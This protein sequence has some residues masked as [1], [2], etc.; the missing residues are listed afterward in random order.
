MN[1]SNESDEHVSRA[2]RI[3]P[4]AKTSSGRRTFLRESTFG[5]V[6]MLTIRQ[7]AYGGRAESDLNNQP[8]AMDFLACLSATNEFVH[9]LREAEQKLRGVKLAPGEDFE[10]RL[11]KAGLKIPEWLRGSGMTYENPSADLAKY[12][13]DEVVIVE[14]GDPGIVEVRSLCGC[15]KRLKICICIE[16]G[17]ILCRIVIRGTF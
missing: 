17:W 6:G 10:V 9:F 7:L 5:A 4:Q 12:G 16:C 11:E 2:S 13:S 15:I 8:A 3:P 14:P 1:H